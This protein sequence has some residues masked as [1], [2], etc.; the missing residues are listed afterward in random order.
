MIYKHNNLHHDK[1]IKSEVLMKSHAPRNLNRQKM[2][3][4]YIEGYCKEAIA[5][6]FVFCKYSL[7]GK[8]LNSYTILYVFCTCK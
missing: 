8:L 1:L 5:R 3:D 7:H 4:L 6:K 2:R